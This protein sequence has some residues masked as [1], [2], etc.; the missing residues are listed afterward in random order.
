MIP[1]GLLQLIMPFVS[2][3]FLQVENTKQLIDE[4]LDLIE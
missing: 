4:I 1:L 2:D 3:L